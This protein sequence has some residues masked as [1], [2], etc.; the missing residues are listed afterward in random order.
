MLPL[1]SSHQRCVFNSSLGRKA[2]LRDIS[3]LCRSLLGLFWAKFIIGRLISL[4]PV[5]ERCAANT[6]EANP[7][8]HWEGKLATVI[9]HRR[10][11]PLLLKADEED[12]GGKSWFTRA[13]IS[14][15]TSWGMAEWA[16][17]V[18]K[19]HETFCWLK[20]NIR[21]GCRW[22]GKGRLAISC[23]ELLWQTGYLP[24]CY[25]LVTCQALCCMCLII[26]IGRQRHGELCK[27][28]LLYIVTK[29]PGET[30]S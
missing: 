19:N 21:R 18:K 6:M 27:I 9:G 16:V 20:Q 28:G 4:L 30:L 15:E 11:S 2:G 26:A 23:E 24:M 12:F 22:S 29:T 13:W 17:K 1:L 25:S 5:G 10:N 8:Q 3:I 14:E 7:T